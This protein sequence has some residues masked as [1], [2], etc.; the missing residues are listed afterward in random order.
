MNERREPPGLP[1]GDPAPSNTQAEP[2]PNPTTGWP[3]VTY[4]DRDWT[5][6]VNEGHLDVWQRIK[7][8]RPYKAAVPPLIADLEPRLRPAA[9]TAASDAT[10]EVTRFDTEMAGLPVPMPAVLLRTESAS[11]SQI[12]HLTSNARNIALAE[13]GGPGKENASL[14]VANAHAMTTALNAGDAVTAETIL[15]IHAALLQSTE[16]D[17]AGAWR[18]QQVWIGS[19]PISPHDAGFVPPHADRVP[20]LI[21]DLCAFGQRADVPPLV[22]AAL[23]HA[24]FET[25]HPFIDGNGRTGRVLVHTVLRDHGITRHTTVPVSAGLLR[26]PGRYFDALGAYRDGDPNLIVTEMSAAA[27]AAVANGRQ[28]A[29]EILSIRQQ[30]RDQIK[31]RTDSS[32]WRLADVLFAQPVINVDRA[33]ADLGVSAPAARASLATLVDAGVLTPTSDARRNRVWQATSVLAAIDAFSRRA[34][35]RTAGR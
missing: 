16:T 6:T 23:L 15:A 22:H 20:E 35:R 2:D 28:L 33:V 19:S 30:W 26:A 11:S 21:D 10:N 8:A 4:E 9:L 13:L 24:Q 18:D 25:I 3:P 34:G 32:A 5:S 29:G 27:L 17:H 12:E 1:P 7:N 31:A 14:I